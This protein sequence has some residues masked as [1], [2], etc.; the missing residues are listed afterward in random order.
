MIHRDLKEK[1]LFLLDMDG[2]IYLDDSL[3]GKYC[4]HVCKRIYE[5]IATAY[6]FT[7][8]MFTMNGA[9]IDLTFDK[10]VDE[11]KYSYRN[12][13]TYGFVTT[14]TKALRFPGTAAKTVADKNEKLNQADIDDLIE[15]L[16]GA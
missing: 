11:K 12:I 9:V 3:F 10:N 14:N 1:K 15:K 4:P 7:L 16:L 5:E 2:T 8:M 13:L 6:N